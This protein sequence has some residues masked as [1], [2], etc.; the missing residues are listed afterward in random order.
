MN[1]HRFAR[2]R[3]EEEDEDDDDDDDDDEPCLPSSA[4]TGGVVMRTEA[5]TRSPLHFYSPGKYQSLLS[6]IIMLSR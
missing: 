5:M 2:R 4:R 6:D 3:R 1:P